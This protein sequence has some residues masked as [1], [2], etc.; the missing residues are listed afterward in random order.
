L[1][2]SALMV[3]IPAFAT[4]ALSLWLAVSAAFVSS[5]PHH[6]LLACRRMELLGVSPESSIAEEGM[7]RSQVT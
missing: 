6:L 2:A 5:V 1:V 4:P 3:G 7:M